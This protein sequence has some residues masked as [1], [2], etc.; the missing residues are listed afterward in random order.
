MKIA[1][2]GQKAIPSRT[3]GIEIHVEE[4]SKRIVKKGIGINVYC[5]KGYCEQ[6]HNGKYEGINI[7]YTPF[8]KSKHLDAITHTL[9]ATIHA[10]F[11]GCD[12]FHYHALGPSTLAF[13]PRLFGRKVICTVHGLDW[14]R[15]KWKGF[16]TKYLKFGEYA[17]AKF[18][19][20]TINVS[21]N[22]V[23][24]YK[25]KY[26]LDT[27]Y[28]PNG[29]EEPETL[30]ADIIKTKYGL[31]KNDYILFLA[32][33]VPEKGVH[34]LIE[35][36]KKLKTQ[37]K[38][39]IAGGSSHSNEYEK[40]LHDMAKGNNNIIFTGFVSGRELEELY[41]NA[42]IYVLPSDVEGLPI[43]L[44]EA[45]SYGKACLVSDIPQNLE[46]IQKGKED[47]YGFSFRSGNIGSLAKKLDYLLNN[48]VLLERMGIEVQNHVIKEYNWDKITDETL[49]I[50][51]QVLDKKKNKYYHQLNKDKEA[52]TLKI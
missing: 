31:S 44:L 48:P 14:Q 17:T 37:K 21:Q 7:C 5:R 18:S 12:I 29:V 28:I 22:L 23:K 40:E 24:Y 19:H 52:A 2:I 51:R 9:T 6:V 33:L 45:M 26:G 16:A 36:Y 11:S 34:Y 25:D 43:S 10:L 50:Y 39:V 46:V 3:G 30:N 42:Y 49:S 8:I 32:R 15:G 27:Q 4:I 35:A 13:L 1:M 47:R 38:L 41:S 20:K